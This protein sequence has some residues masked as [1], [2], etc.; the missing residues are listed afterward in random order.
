MLNIQVK[1]MLNRH[2]KTMLNK[3]VKT[4]LNRQIKAMLNRQIK[5]TL[6]RQMKTTLNRQIKTMLNRE[7]SPTEERVGR[8]SHEELLHRQQ[9]VEDAHDTHVVEQHSEFS[10][11][12]GRAK[13]HLHLQALVAGARACL[14]LQDAGEHIGSRI[15]WLL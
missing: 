12:G 5:T 1:T 4:I 8:L 15:H 2:I 11:V 14:R 7:S 3:Q 13:V 10:A 6:N 9:P